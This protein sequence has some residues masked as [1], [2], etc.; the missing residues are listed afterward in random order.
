VKRKPTERRR[1]HIDRG[2]RAFLPLSR[3]RRIRWEEACARSYAKRNRIG[4]YCI[5]HVVFHCGIECMGIPVIKK[6]SR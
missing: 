6:T 4:A 1:L 5:E 2:D 3:M